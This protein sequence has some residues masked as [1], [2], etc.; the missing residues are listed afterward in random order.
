[1][2]PREKVM[3]TGAGGFIGSHLA[4][5]LA[6]RGHRVAAVDLQL[7]RLAHLR[8]DPRIALHEGDVT[9]EAL[10]RPALEEVDTVFHLAAAHLTVA[11]GDAEFWRV[12]VDGLGELVGWSR[13][14]G[15]RRFVQCSSVG[16]FGRIADP[17]ADE[18]SP[19]RPDI[20][21]ERSKLA[22]EE[23]VL[24][25]CRKGFPATILRPAWVYGPGCPRTEKLF[26]SIAKGRFV[27]AGDGSG[28]RHCIYIRDMVDAFLLAS[29]REEAL[30]QV[31]IVGDAEPVTI[32]T[33]VDGIARQVGARPP[34]RVPMALL[35]G[36]ATVAELVFKPLGKEPPLS[37]RTLK[38]FTANTAF[39]ISR[40]RTLLGFE[41]RYDLDAGLEETAGLLGS[42][43]P[44]ALRPAPAIHG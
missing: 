37:R 14:A 8:D 26:R 12:N 5:E 35:A 38:F 25:A 20:A 32:R 1:M 41:P 3:V 21:Y 18:S 10:L 6:R 27:V 28:L 40:A 30:G 9:A 33:L 44:W 11:A 29:E 42:P 13:E 43:E 39:D 23:V 2:T 7:D 34:R 19:C 16:V 4:V 36:A 15:V 24:D 22:G 17:P 31:M